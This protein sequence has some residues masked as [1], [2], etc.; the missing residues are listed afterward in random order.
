[1]PS[2]DSVNRCMPHFLPGSCRLLFP[3]LSGV[4]CQGTQLSLHIPAGFH[5]LS[6]Y[7]F[8]LWNIL[9]LSLPKTYLFCSFFFLDKCF[10]SSNLNEPILPKVFAVLRGFTMWSHCVFPTLCNHQVLD[11]QLE[12]SF[13]KL[14]CSCYH[15]LKQN[16][17][18]SIVLW[19]RTV[20]PPLLGELHT[21]LRW[22]CWS[23]CKYPYNARENSVT[24]H[25][26]HG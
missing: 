1:M 5:F 6:I 24:G 19:V 11:L 26:N 21:N 23:D 10:Y 13:L 4:H 25:A 3:L 2:C 16:L 7:G 15:I 20:L 9:Y 14:I 12:R 22:G 18:I 8:T 17:G